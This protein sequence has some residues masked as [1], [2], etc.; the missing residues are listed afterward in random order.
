MTKPA[1]G[2]DR[3]DDHW[4]LPCE[5]LV[6]GQIRIDYAYGLEFTETPTRA[7]DCSWRLRVE[8]LFTFTDLVGVVHSLDPE[9]PAEALAPALVVRHQQLV[10]GDIWANGRICMAFANG[11]SLNIEPHERYEAWTLTS[12]PIDGFPRLLVC[13]I[14]A[15]EVDW[16][17]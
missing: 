7:A 9:G 5:G 6:V 17:G 12:D 15:D 11:T 8:T 3:R 10:H 16:S 13:T 2:L 1:K 4:V 14:G